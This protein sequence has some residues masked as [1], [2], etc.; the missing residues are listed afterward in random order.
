MK[1][2]RDSN[3]VIHP[4]SLIHPS[5]VMDSDV[6][7]GQDCKIWHFCHILSGTRIGQNCSFGQN[8]VIGPNVK[9]G[10]G[11]KVQNNVS[12]YEGVECEDDVFIGPSV[13]FTN[14]INPRAFIVRK[15]EYKKTTL[16]KGCTIG[17][18]AT[19]VCGITIGEYAFVGAGAVVREAVKPFALVVGI[20]ARQIGWVDKAGNKMIF[21]SQNRAIDSYDGRE[22]VLVGDEIRAY[23]N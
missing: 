10:N 21:D 2:W 19:I 13:V 12:I 5:S 7:I 14:V 9:I 17:A 18:N 20:P 8:C 1:S 6:L 23:E 15:N 16:K 4:S 22:Y 11:C 3:S